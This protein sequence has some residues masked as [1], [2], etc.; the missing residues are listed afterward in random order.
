MIAEPILG[1]LYRACDLP[2]G[3]VVVTTTTTEYVIG[4][5]GCCMRWEQPIPG[6]EDWRVTY[7]GRLD[8]EGSDR[9]TPR[10]RAE[11]DDARRRRA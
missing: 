1:E 9:M 6:S 5:T 7:A 8:D 11:V 10:E 3:A 4:Y 2:P